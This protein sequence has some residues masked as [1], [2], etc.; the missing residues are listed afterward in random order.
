M[1]I[2]TKIAAFMLT[3][4]I[5]GGAMASDIQLASSA[6]ESVKVNYADLNIDAMAGA[7]VLYK[8]IETAAQK[9][10]G[11]SNRRDSLDVVQ[12]Q[13]SCVVNVVESAVKK[14]DSNVVDSIHYS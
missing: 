4:I 10:C 13:K 7:N 12:S 8:R 2:P 5:S 14:V 11:V 1:N 6:H 9:L 3:T